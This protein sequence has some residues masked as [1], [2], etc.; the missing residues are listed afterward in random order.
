MTDNGLTIKETAKVDLANVM[1]LW[2][3]GEV[4]HFVGFPDGLGMSM[5]K[6][7]RWLEWAINKPARC[8][9]SIYHDELGYCGETFYSVDEHGLAALDI[10]LLPKARGKGI[11]REALSFAIEQ[12]FGPGQAKSVYV[13]PHVN[14]KNAWRLYERLGFLPKPRPEHLEENETYLEISREQWYK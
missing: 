9:Y 10:K 7:E 1:S 3:D 4:M 13:E 8:H 14:N 11:A 5:D 2:N 6:M 12:A